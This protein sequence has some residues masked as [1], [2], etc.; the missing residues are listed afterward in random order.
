MQSN[1]N[2]LVS[3]TVITYN[4]AKYVIETLESIKAQTYPDLELIISDD[5]S[6]DD[7]LDIVRDWVSQT[8]IKER[9]KRIELNT[10]PVNTGVQSNCNRAI[11]TVESKWVKF[12][13]GDDILLPNCIKD[14]MDY[15]AM[16]PEAHII[17]SQVKAY[18]KTFEDKSFTRDIPDEFPNNLMDPE[19]TAQ[20]QYELLLLSDRI[21]YTPSYF[22]LKQSV[23]NV[24]GYDETDRLVEDYPMWL[25][26]TDA[27]N[28]LHYFHKPTVGYR[29]H[30]DATNNKGNS[31]LF[32]PSEVNSYPVRKKYVHPHLHWTIV[33]KEVWRYR[34][35]KI[36]ISLGWT[37]NSAFLRSLYALM[38]VHL[39]P[40]IYLQAINQ[41]IRIKN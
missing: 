8:A 19:F 33:C 35:S 23:L 10:E 37:K 4:S 40:F 26:L 12:I 9:F 31:V 36:F 17:F 20:D 34:V 24:G 15:V 22:F 41:R 14:N 27:G 11:A 6:Q 7:T 39:N 18:N 2:P 5:A 28:R 13:A 21:T 3:V 1:E 30:Q 25:K 32:K 38:T 29:Q 16:N